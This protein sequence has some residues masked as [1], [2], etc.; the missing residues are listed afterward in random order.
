[1]KT[2]FKFTLALTACVWM[3]AATAAPPET[4][5][6]GTGTLDF[7]SA[8]FRMQSLLG[9][10]TNFLLPDGNPLPLNT[11]QYSI[12]TKSATL[13]FNSATISDTTGKVS[14]NAG[15]SQLSLYAVRPQEDEYG[16]Y[17]YDLPVL[18][19]L[20]A[21]RNI[22]FD[23]SDASIH[24]DITSY[25]GTADGI[26]LVD[27]FGRITVFKG[28]APITDGTQGLIVDG[29]ASGST[30]GGL[31][32]T[33]EGADIVLN[34]LYAWS[35]VPLDKETPGTIYTVGKTVN[36]GSASASG[37]FASSVPEASTQAL[38]LVGLLPLLAFS[39]RARR[40]GR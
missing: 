38:M 8:D 12:P 15:N 22:T 11:A 7:Q 16:D 20:V 40:T 33:D 10:R 24:A 27:S 23:L 6:S 31:R 13:S 30:I 35:G 18:I 2:I 36:W 5:V 14:F 26:H 21:L 4:F 39:R 37:T 9:I 25:T 29:H 1:M 32:L 17:N 28:I 3:G 34:G 19:N